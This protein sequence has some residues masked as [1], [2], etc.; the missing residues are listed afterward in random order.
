VKDSQC[1]FK[2]FKGAVAKDVFSRLQIYN[3][4]DTSVITSA[5]LGAWDVEVLYVA[6][7]LGYTIKEI[8]VKWTYVKTTRLSHVR[9]SLKML[10]DLLKIRLNDMKGKYGSPVQKLF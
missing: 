8:P 9:D 6:K 2:L 3:G 10:N 5:Y 4:T 7:K 1:G